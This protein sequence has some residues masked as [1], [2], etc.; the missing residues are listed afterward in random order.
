[1][2]V[3]LVAGD[4]TVSEIARAVGWLDP[5]YAA[6]RFRNAYQMSPTDYRRRFAVAQADSGKNT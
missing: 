3:Q 6:R 2:A 4:R 1:M 5:N